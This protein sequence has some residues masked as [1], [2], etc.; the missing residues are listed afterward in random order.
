MSA[1][2]SFD[3]NIG[4]ESPGDAEHYPVTLNPYRGEDGT[5]ISGLTGRIYFRIGVKENADFVPTKE[6]D[7]K[8]G[9]INLSYYPGWRT[10]MKIYIRQGEARCLYICAGGCYSG[11]C[12][13]SVE[14]RYG[15]YYTCERRYASFIDECP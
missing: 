13:G 7:P 10:T 3:P 6:S 2:P 5:S 11:N 14:W 1:T 15:Y 8:F 4:T 9:Y 12:M